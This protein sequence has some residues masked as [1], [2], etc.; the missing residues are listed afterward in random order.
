MFSRHFDAVMSG[1]TACRNSAPVL[2]RSL[3]PSSRL[4]LALDQLAA[5]AARFEEA[6]RLSA[7]RSGDG[8]EGD[9]EGGQ[10][11]TG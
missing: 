4:H 1:A 5:A 8:T 6:C 9:A 11:E 10:A 3:P 7:E 2:M